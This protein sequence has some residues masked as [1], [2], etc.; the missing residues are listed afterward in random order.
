[1]HL[2]RSLQY[3]A[4]DEIPL[5][6]MHD[7]YIGIAAVALTVNTNCDSISGMV[8]QRWARTSYFSILLTVAF[9]FFLSIT[10]LLNQMLAQFRDLPMPFGTVCTIPDMFIIVDIS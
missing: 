9:A 6:I 2:V 8:A 3:A 10:I 7:S 1:M 5:T 4:D